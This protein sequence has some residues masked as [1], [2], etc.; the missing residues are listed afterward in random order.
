MKKIAKAKPPV[1]GKANVWIIGLG[2]NRVLGRDGKPTYFLDDARDFPTREKAEAAITPEVRA[3]GGTG[4]DSV[5][6][7]KRPV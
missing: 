5:M 4:Y 1:Q 7:T 6:A 3:L 2:N